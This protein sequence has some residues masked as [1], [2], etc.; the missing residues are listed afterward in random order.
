MPGISKDRCKVAGIA[1]QVMLK[2]LIDTFPFKI[3]FLTIVCLFG[4]TFGVILAVAGAIYFFFTNNSSSQAQPESISQAAPATASAYLAVYV[5]GAI[6]NAGVY[7]LESGSRINDVITLAGG[8]SKDADPVYIA[9]DLNLATSVSDGLQIYIPYQVET[10]SILSEALSVNS[11][12]TINYPISINNADQ[13][14]LESLPSI[15]SK[16]AQDI[17]SNRPYSSLD[18]LVSK[19]VISITLFEQIQQSISI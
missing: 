6:K 11:S 16:R 1:S 9:K 14:Q 19:G 8:F 4:L 2:D 12:E 3:N 17:I 13:D 10:E 5:S 18:E 15:G 7:E